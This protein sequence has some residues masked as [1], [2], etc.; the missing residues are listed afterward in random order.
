MYI[1]EEITKSSFR[2]AFYRTG[3][4]AGSFS[5]EALGA[6]F[7]YYAEIAEQT[8]EPIELGV[9]SVNCN[10][11][12][13]SSWKEATEQW[14]MTEEDIRDSHYVIEFDG[15]ILISA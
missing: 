7:D 15:G 1:Y 6:L 4:Y 11:A 12:E 10:W 3:T 9:V 14:D 5:Y 8:A 13:V 2:E